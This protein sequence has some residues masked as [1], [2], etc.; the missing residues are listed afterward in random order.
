VNG[1]LLHA[2]AAAFRYPQQVTPVG[3]FSFALAAGELHL[4]QGPSGSG[5]STLARLL[6]GVIPHLYRGDLTGR[7]EVDGV[8]SAALPFWRVAERVGLVTQNPAAQLLTS[9]VRAEIGFG[10]ERLSAHAAARRV[11]ATIEAFGLAPLAERDPQTLSGGEQQ[12]VVIAAIAARRPGALV[13]DEPLS[14]LDTD[15]V[16]MVTAQLDRL[17]RDGVGVVVCEHRADAFAQLEGVRHQTIADHRGD[18]A[19]TAV[20][21]PWDGPSPD[22]VAALRLVGGQLRAERGGRAVLR[23]VDLELEGGQVVSLVGPNGAGKTTLLRVIAGLQPHQ[24]PLHVVVAGRSRQPRMAM[25]FQLPDRQLFNPSV[26]SEITFGLSSCDEQRYRRVVDLLGLASYEDTAPL[27][28]S[29]GEKKRLGLA[30]MLMRSGLHGICLDE[31]TLGQDP[32]NSRLLGR[33]ARRLAAAGY[34]CIAA[35]HDRAW[36]AAWSDRLITLRDGCLVAVE[37]VRGR[38]ASEAAA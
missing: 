35:T 14:M 32:A 15:A 5:K 8:A 37:D 17:R 25:C 29:E 21:I 34:L 13:L 9:N 6:G 23:D 36:A 1:T 4:V 19:R 30:I 31:P 26:R 38:G 27:L 7:V 10:L 18:A 16:G 3:P 12:K 2:A 11:D 28:L 22:T 33:V 24:G 20:P